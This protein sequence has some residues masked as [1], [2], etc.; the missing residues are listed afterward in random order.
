MKEDTS[1]DTCVQ[2]V[3]WTQSKLSLNLPHY[4]GMISIWNVMIRGKEEEEEDE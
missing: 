1:Q 2:A 3:T 4:A